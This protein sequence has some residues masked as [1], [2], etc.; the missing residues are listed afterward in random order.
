MRRDMKGGID[1][2]LRIGKLEGLIVNDDI[3]FLPE[4]GIAKKF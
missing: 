3:F 2:G 4:R 1:M